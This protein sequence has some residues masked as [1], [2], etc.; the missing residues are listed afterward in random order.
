[1]RKWAIEHVANGLGSRR[2]IPAASRRAGAYDLA[3]PTRYLRSKTCMP[4]TVHVIGR[5]FDF[6]F[7][8]QAAYRLHFVDETHLDVTVIADASYP[9]GT[10]NHFEIEMTEI[11]PDVHMI[12]W[13]EPQ[14]GN[15]VT[16]VDDFANNIAY[17][18]ITD[19]ASK[20]FWRLKGEIKP[21][22]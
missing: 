21:L 19:L 20:G 22:T 8:D 3:Y 11:R 13:V 7:G 4:S 2:S 1:M 18:N 9:P 16:H 12:T 10:V 6:D 5:E 17:T 14:T 15:T